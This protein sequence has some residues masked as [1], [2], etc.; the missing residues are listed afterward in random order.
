[1]FTQNVIVEWGAPIDATKFKLQYSMDNGSTW[2]PM[3]SDFVT[4]NSYEW[5]VVPIPSKNKPKCLVK[6][7]AYWVG[8]NG[9]DVKIG[10]DVSDAFTI[11]VASITAPTKDE[12]VPKGT[13]GYPVTWVT[14]GI[15]EKVN[16]AQVLY[17]LG[18]SGIWQ[19][20]TPTVVGVLTGF[21]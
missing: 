15:S 12:I 11:E 20:A 14:H 18:S 5:K 17:T 16:S 4:S 21:N 1:M 7:D 10:T 6:I 8:Y 19:K 3:A 9:N 13:V 2:K